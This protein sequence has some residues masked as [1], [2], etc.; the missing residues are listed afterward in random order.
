MTMKQFFLPL[1]AAAYAATAAEQATPPYSV[2]LESVSLMYIYPDEDSDFRDA[3][4]NSLNISL[5][6][7]G[8]SEEMQKIISTETVAGSIRIVDS[9]GKD[10][11]YSGGF[12]SAERVYLNSELSDGNSATVSGT[13]ALNLCEQ[14]VVKESP[15]LHPADNPT[16]VE[17]EYSFTVSVVHEKEAEH[18]AIRITYKSENGT[19]MGDVALTDANGK[20]LESYGCMMSGNDAEGTIDHQ[21]KQIPEAVK[22]R[23]TQRPITKT[24]HLPFCIRFSIC[25]ELAPKKE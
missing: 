25:G 16:F 14:D 11:K 19:D 6:V 13:L 1:L 23:W 4:F 10:L 20:E 15:I 3:P 8:P 5:E 18:P 21:V 2:N 17:G 22:I 7:T 24:I 12:T 9:T